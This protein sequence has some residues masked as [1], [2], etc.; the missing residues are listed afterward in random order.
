M[1]QNDSQTDADLRAE[2][3]PEPEHDSEI[4]SKPEK[5]TETENEEESK[6]EMDTEASSE[7]EEEIEVEMTSK[8]SDSNDGKEN[9][10]NASKEDMKNMEND[11]GNASE[12]KKTESFD[13]AHT[14]ASETIKENI[15]MPKDAQTVPEDMATSGSDMVESVVN[16]DT[17][18]DNFNAI[19]EM[20]R[21][22]NKSLENAEPNDKKEP[23]NTA[24]D[25][26]ATN[27][28]AS[29]FLKNAD[30]DPSDKNSTDGKVAFEPKVAT[31]SDQSANTSNNTTESKFPEVGEEP[32]DCKESED[33][34]AALKAL[35]ENTKANWTDHNEMDNGENSKEEEHKDDG[36]H[37][38]LV[39]DAEIINQDGVT[40]DEK[41]EQALETSAKSLSEMDEM[42]NDMRDT[43][44]EENKSEHDKDVEDTDDEVG[45]GEVMEEQYIKEMTPD[46]QIVKRKDLEE[47]G[48]E[49]NQ[50]NEKEDARDGDEADTET[51]T[52]DQTE[53]MQIPGGAQQK[54]SPDDNENAEEEANSS[55]E[56]LEENTDESAVHNKSTAKDK[57][58]ASTSGTK[59]EELSADTTQTTYPEPLSNQESQEVLTMT[60]MLQTTKAAQADHSSESS[61]EDAEKEMV[62]DEMSTST[63]PNP[64][65]NAGKEEHSEEKSISKKTPAGSNIPTNV[66]RI[67]VLDP[68]ETQTAG[69]T[70]SDSQTA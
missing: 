68:E 31:T 24:L 15:L 60:A 18:E 30:L 33:I 44:S 51:D 3:G 65:H 57:P 26:V 27:F 21:M 38:Q 54:N 37:A 14:D 36:K 32:C 12:D 61:G 28:T 23:V 58:V 43:T 50:K 8:E 25:E 13:I 55:A 56:S 35:D 53:D 10:A 62:T 4:M 67:N 34:T 46:I 19:L 66:V 29:I 17:E 70:S 9:D 48:T 64:T 1:I 69:E 52:D 20:E 59:A 22:L 41:S 6:P 16:P 7:M 49:N 40:G 63:T 47:E 2:T 11:S 5:R 45:S 39:H 42:M